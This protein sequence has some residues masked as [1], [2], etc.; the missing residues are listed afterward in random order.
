MKSWE[1][2][3]A[4]PLHRVHVPLLRIGELLVEINDPVGV[5]GQNELPCVCTLRDL[6]R[7]VNDDYASQTSHFGRSSRKR[8]VCMNA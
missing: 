2:G 8:P 6:M 7:D 5:V 1:E 3:L 4:S